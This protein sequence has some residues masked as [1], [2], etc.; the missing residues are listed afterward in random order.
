MVVF[1]KGALVATAWMDNKMVT[2]MS[3]NCEDGK[4]SSKL[5]NKKMDDK[6]FPALKPFCDTQHICTVL[7]TVIKFA[8]TIQYKRSPE[9]AFATYSGFYLNLQ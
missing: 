5:G 2:V 6:N 4:L 1:Q 9:N 7:I 3:T 8:S